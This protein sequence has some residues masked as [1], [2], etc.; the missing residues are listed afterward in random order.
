MKPACF[1]LLSLWLLTPQ[2]SLAQRFQTISIAEE[3]VLLEEVADSSLIFLFEGIEQAVITLDNGTPYTASIN[4]NILGDAMQTQTRRGIQTIDPHQVNRVELAG[5]VFIHH[6]E[7]GYLEVLSEKRFPLFLKRTIQ[8]SAVPVVRGAYGTKD[9]TSSID[10]ACYITTGP[11][12]EFYLTNST[13]KEMDIT[14]RYNEYFLIGKDER[15]LKISNQ[16]QLLRDFPEYRN[17]IRDFLRKKNFNFQDSDDLKKLL[18]FLEEL[19]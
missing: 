1:A 3:K 17:Q 2:A 8:I 7:E 19:P 11:S 16:R 4:Y 18:T 10:Q 6:W 9:H 13:G 15:L 12:G 14:L 5:S